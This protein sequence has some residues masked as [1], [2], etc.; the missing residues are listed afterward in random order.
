M[1]AFEKRQHN[2]FING[3]FNLERRYTLQDVEEIKIERVNNEFVAV[4][5]LRSMA[6]MS[7][8][9]TF[10]RPRADSR[11]FYGVKKMKNT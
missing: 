5:V 6:L 8:P 11:D 3:T 1:S 7:T 9:N 4:Y 10:N 2:S